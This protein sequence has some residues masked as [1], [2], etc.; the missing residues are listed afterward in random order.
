[1]NAMYERENST[2]L[3]NRFA[4]PYY[5]ALFRVPDTYKSHRFGPSLLFHC[6]SFAHVC[7]SYTFSVPFLN[8]FFLPSSWHLFILFWFSIS[9]FYLL[10]I[11]ISAFFFYVFFLLFFLYYFFKPNSFLGDYLFTF[12][13][14]FCFPLVFCLLAHVFVR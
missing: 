9:F 14:H 11:A 6:C 12:D 4:K 1:M 13:F 8:G 5:S 10:V 3:L 7:T 2:K